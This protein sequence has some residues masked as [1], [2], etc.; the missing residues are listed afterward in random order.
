[1]FREVASNVRMIGKKLIGE[2]I[3]DPT[4]NQLTVGGEMRPLEPRLARLLEMLCNAQGEPV[5][6][7]DLLKTVSTLPH[8]GDEVLTQAMSRLRQVLGDDPKAPRYIKTVPRRGYALVAPVS[9]YA[10]PQTEAE[11]TS[12]RLRRHLPWYVAA[13]AVLVA[14][15]LAGYLYDRQIYS[16][17]EIEFHEKSDRE[18]IEKQD[19]APAE[20]TPDG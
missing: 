10:G 6:R 7:D 16:D 15:F 13:A 2:I 18:F 3:F 1:M 8:A 11:A 20:V 14:V 12:S 4:C 5:A 19:D 9:D 17:I